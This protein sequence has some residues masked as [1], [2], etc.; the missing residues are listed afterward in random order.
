MRVIFFLLVFV[1]LIVVAQDYPDS[2][3]WKIELE[4]VNHGRVTTL[5]G[6]LEQLK[7]IG[8]LM[9]KHVEKYMPDDN[10][11]ILMTFAGTNV[12]LHDTL[13]VKK[14]KKF[15]SEHSILLS[16]CETFNFYPS[17]WRNPYE[18]NDQLG[19][20]AEI[21]QVTK[22]AQGTGSF[23]MKGKN[24]PNKRYAC[25][26]VRV[27]NGWDMNTVS[28]NLPQEVD[29]ANLWFYMD[30]YGRGDSDAVFTLKV[31]E[32]GKDA[33]Y[34]NNAFDYYQYDI[35]LNFTGWK[36]VA[37]R[38]SDMTSSIFIDMNNNRISGDMSDRKKEVKYLQD[39]NYILSST[40]DDKVVEVNL[41]NLMI[42]Y[43]KNGNN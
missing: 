33:V 39:I 21:D 5:T 1:P 38:Y 34:N 35:P 7:N 4:R 6:N 28:I 32:R 3:S 40:K 15:L 9:H 17:L 29:S 8:Q 22:P 2:L 20:L 42:L 19:V 37:V 13:P 12:S 11:S 31:R 23:H 30:V 26:L 10:I 18:G 41:D 27:L 14:V 24:Y 43:N 36:Q 16:Y 25:S